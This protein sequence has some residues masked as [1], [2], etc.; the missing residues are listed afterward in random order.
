[1]VELCY[2]SYVKKE[3]NRNILNE[4]IRKRMFLLEATN[5]GKPC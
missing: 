5:D 1:M 4:A 3:Q 2:N